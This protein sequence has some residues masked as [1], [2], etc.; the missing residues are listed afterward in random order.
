MR[1]LIQK[2]KSKYKVNTK[3]MNLG[4]SNLSEQTNRTIIKEARTLAGKLKGDFLAIS[5]SFDPITASE[6]VNLT[7]DMIE[8]IEEVLNT[9]NEFIRNNEFFLQVKDYLQEM[10]DNRQ[11]I[12][13]EEFYKNFKTV[14][15]LHYDTHRDDREFWENMR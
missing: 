7:D 2:F 12:L 9:E 3:D 13:N 4:K 1:S 11:I 5:Y 6:I 14:E 10:I 8:I 15:M